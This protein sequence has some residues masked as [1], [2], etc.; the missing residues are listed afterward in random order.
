MLSVQQFCNQAD[1]PEHWKEEDLQKYIA[2]KLISWGYTANLEVHVDGGRAD[3]VTNWLGGAVIEVKKY[4]E[5]ST[6]F[7]AYGQANTYVFGLGNQKLKRVIMGFLTTDPQKYQTA[8]NVAKRLMAD[9]N[10]K[11]IFVNLEKAWLPGIEVQRSPFN[12][13]NWQWSWKWDWN[14]S[15]IQS[16]SQLSTWTQLAKK[17]PLLLVLIACGFFAVAT[18]DYSKTKKSPVKPAIAIAGYAKAIINIRDSSLLL[19]QKRL[20]NL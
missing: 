12:L 16:F 14:F 5:H 11:V 10:N 18:H 13:F 7:G 8:I 4:L 6:I 2:N 9:P 3:I 19:V 17:H 1:F 15:F 20:N